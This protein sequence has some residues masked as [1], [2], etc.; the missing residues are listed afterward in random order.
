MSKKKKL[1]IETPE[2]AEPL[3]PEYIRYRGAY[4]GRASGKSWFFA[5]LMIERHYLRQPTFSVCIREI[6]KDLKHSAKRLLEI[7]I[8]KFGL[9]PWFEIQQS[10]I[11]TPGG[12]LIIFQGMQSHNS[13]SIKSLESYDVAWIEEAQTISQRSLDLLRPTIRKEDSEIWASWNPR[14]EHDPIDVFLRSTNT[15]PDAVV[16][17]CNYDDN[18]WLP[19]IMLREMEYDKRRDPDK[20][21]HVWKG[22]YL[23]NSE[24]R[25]F[26]N[27]TID[28]FEA[29]MDAVHRFGADWGFAVD[30]T[31][32][33]RSHIIGRKLYIDYEAYQVGCEILDIPDLFDTV[34]ESRHWPIIA[35]SERPDTI[36][37]LRTNGF[38]KIYPAVKGP[39]S[40]KEGVEWLK[41]FEIIVHPRCKHTI[42]ELSLYSYK[43]DEATDKVLPIL[44]DAN[45]H[46]IDS[47]RYSHEGLRRAAKEKEQQ[48]HRGAAAPLPVNN[49]MSRRK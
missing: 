34:P 35:D 7:Q 5:G 22:E 42:D 16:V 28:E 21:A 46:V 41:T 10:Q 1:R 9:G 47:L 19:D 45:N 4:G 13:E 32:L 38:P 2:W 12:G 11:K 18:N 44:Q 8:E 36:S 20:Y 29:P 15:P 48:Q 33:V 6:Q 43:I 39:S 40:V 23:R 37:H 17:R 3:L 27:W 14:Y 26:K 24:S 30:P 25:V 49:P 31:V